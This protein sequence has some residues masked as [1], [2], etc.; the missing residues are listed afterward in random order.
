MFNQRK[1]QTENIHA[2]MYIVI[3]SPLL[4]SLHSVHF[5]MKLHYL[6]GGGGVTHYHPLAGG[7]GVTHYHPLA[8]G[9]ITHY[10]PLGG[11]TTE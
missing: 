6:V 9:G 10:H 1:P 3:D 11:G 5:T 2:Y 8:G 7:G 4:L